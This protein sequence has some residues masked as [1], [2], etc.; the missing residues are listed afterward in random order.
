MPK[1]IVTIDLQR[2]HTGIPWGFVICGGRDQGLTLKI[3]NVKRMT[4]ASRAGLC[5]M[6]YLI[7]INGRP[8]FNMTHD[9]CCRDIKQSGQVLRLEC[10]RGDHIVPS[11]EELFPGLRGDSS[12]DGTSRKKHIGVDYYQDAMNNHG[13]GHLRQPDNFTTVGNKLSIEINQYNCPI[14]AY[15]DNSIEEMREQ[16]ER[17]GMYNVGMF[18]R[19]PQELK[20]S[21]KF[22]PSKS[23]AIQVIQLEEGGNQN[24]RF[25]G[26]S[27]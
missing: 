20:D 27:T 19:I 25:D 23:N 10:E 13:L 24:Q 5:K 17:G 26:R 7:S 2:P 11:F 14:N 15:S 6:D 12:C 3:G 1:N 4:P 21:R 22:D 8:V 16:K 18:E 9:E